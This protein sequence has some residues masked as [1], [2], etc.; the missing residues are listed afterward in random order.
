MI[1]FCFSS[2]F[3][4]VERWLPIWTNWRFSCCWTASATWWFCSYSYTISSSRGGH[5]QTHRW[6]ASISTGIHFWIT[7]SK[8][9]CNRVPPAFNWA[10]SSS[11]SSSSRFQQP[12]SSQAHA[13]E[14]CILGW[15]SQDVHGDDLQSQQKHHQPQQKQPSYAYYAAHMDWVETDVSACLS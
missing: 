5:A 7:D 1:A 13:C 6:G 12:S 11:S 2:E 14:C 3:G 15:E 4:L 9:W 10:Y 8:H